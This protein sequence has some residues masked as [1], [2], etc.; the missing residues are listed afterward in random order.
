MQEL[1]IP[2][3]LSIQLPSQLPGLASA[4]ILLTRMT[5]LPIQTA[6]CNHS[7]SLLHMGVRHPPSPPSR[8]HLNSRAQPPSSFGPLLQHPCS[9]LTLMMPKTSSLKAAPYSLQP[10]LQ[11]ISMLPQALQHLLRQLLLQLLSQ[12]LSTAQLGMS[13]SLQRPSC[14]LYHHHHMYSQLHSHHVYSHQHGHDQAF[15]QRLFKLPRMLCPK[16]SSRC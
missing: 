6:R 11:A 15:H 12:L 13:N 7:M 3:Q 10:A 9:N 5:T 14:S 16:R 8:P 4:L 1:P 2:S